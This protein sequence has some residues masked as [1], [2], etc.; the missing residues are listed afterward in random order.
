MVTKPEEVCVAGPAGVFGT[1][2]VISVLIP[3]E[4][5]ENDNVWFDV[6]GKVNEVFPS[7]GRLS[8][9]RE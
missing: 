6:P 5:G 7:D 9:G 1:L 4:V 8:G 3:V 2:E